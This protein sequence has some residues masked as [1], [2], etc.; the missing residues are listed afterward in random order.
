MGTFTVPIE[1]GDLEGNNFA[2]MDALVDTGATYSMVPRDVL[3]ELNVSSHETDYFSLADDSI[4]EYHLGYARLR[5]QQREVIA[6]VIFA[7]EGSTPLLGVTT[8]ERVGFGV[9]PVH[10]RL[11][12]V[13]GL[14]EQPYDGNGQFP[15]G[16]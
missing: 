8:L 9:D 15:A 4:V 12:P 2:A 13:T 7:L 11:V 1:V 10:E 6:I 14:L 16:P 3:A 5:F